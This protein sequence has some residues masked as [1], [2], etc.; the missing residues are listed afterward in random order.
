MYSAKG[1]C[2]WPII[3]IVFLIFLIEWKTFKL[4]VF[5]YFPFSDPVQNCL[6]SVVMSISMSQVKSPVFHPVSFSVFRFRN[7][8]CRPKQYHIL[9]GRLSTLKRFPPNL[10][11]LSRVS[12]IAFSR[13]IHQLYLIHADLKPERLGWLEVVLGCP[14]KLGSMVSK[15]VITYL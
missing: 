9:L 13:Y 7:C 12:R 1:K 3:W 10:R 14:R 4:I 2:P 5:E 8:T 6:K 11:V 15:W